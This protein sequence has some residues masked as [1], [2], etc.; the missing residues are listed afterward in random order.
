MPPVGVDNP[1]FSDLAEPKVKRHRRVFDIL[2]QTTVGLDHY[3]LND[4]ADVD[5]PLNFAVQ[6]HLDH[7]PQGLAMPLKQAVDGVFVTASNI[8]QKLFRLFGF[9]PHLIIIT[10]QV[11][12]EQVRTALV[13]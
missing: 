4:V 7:P 3:I 5:P 12:R 6:P 9:R 13:K 1:I 10:C 2:G 8:R 11:R